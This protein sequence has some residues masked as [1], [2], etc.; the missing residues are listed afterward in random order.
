MRIPADDEIQAL[1]RAHAPGREA[2]D[3][4]WTHCAIVCEIAEQIMERTG[5]DVDRDLVRAGCL[6]HDIGVYRL[7]DDTGRID[8]KQYVRHGVLGH[9]LLRE[10]G[11]PEEICRFCSCHTGMGLTRDDIERQGLPVPPGDYVA[12]S[13]EE[14]LVM[15]ADK[16]HSKTNPPAFVSAETYAVHVRRFGDEKAAAFTAMRA[17]FGEP[18]LEPLA[19]EHGHAL[20]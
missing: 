11:F 9:E 13:G 14:R 1:H 19:A 8:F 12:E 3:L 7:Y 6:L 18:D 15:Y 16:F 17:V 4:V 2:F 10:E 5:P 20:V